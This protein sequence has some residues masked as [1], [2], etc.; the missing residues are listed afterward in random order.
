VSRLFRSLSRPLTSQGF[1][2]KAGQ[3]ACWCASIAIMM[4]GI[5]KLGRLPLNETELFFGVLLVMTVTLLGVLIG[6][7]LPMAAQFD[8]A[9]RPAK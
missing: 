5:L 8:S 7:V 9:P 1:D 4:I 2:V 6:L 3:I